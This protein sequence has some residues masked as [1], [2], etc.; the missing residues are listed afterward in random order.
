[1]WT[2]YIADFDKVQFKVLPRLAALAERGWSYNRSTYDDFVR[3]LFSLRKTYD[4]C[5]YI[6]AGFI[7]DGIE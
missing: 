5:G 3:R 4:A 7:F 6:Y 1:M 2:E